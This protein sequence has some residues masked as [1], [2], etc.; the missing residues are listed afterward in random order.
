LADAC[1][2]HNVEQGVRRPVQLVYP[3]A[4]RAFAPAPLAAE[5]ERPPVLQPD[6]PEC[7]GDVAHGVLAVGEGVL[8]RVIGPSGV[9]LDVPDVV[10]QTAQACEP[11]EVLPRL[12]PE[13]RTAHHAEDHETAALGAHGV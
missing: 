1:R 12:S 10:P 5:T 11:V 2:A 3:V 9:V 4:H 6:M 7:A 8:L 13:R